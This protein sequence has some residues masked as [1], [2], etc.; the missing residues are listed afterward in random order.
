MKIQIRRTKLNGD[1]DIEEN[2]I[3][4]KTL[5][6]VQWKEDKMNF[7]K[8]DD[9]PNSGHDQNSGWSISL[10]PSYVSD[11]ANK[12]LQKEVLLVDGFY[13]NGEIIYAEKGYSNDVVKTAMLINIKEVL[14]C[15]HPKEEVFQLDP[16]TY[17]CS[18]GANVQPLTFKKV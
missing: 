10:T 8:P 7:F 18:C 2:G 15:T 6:R 3:V 17:K 9:F 4:I 13:R 11:L 14:E 5:K 1:C 12:K 16:M